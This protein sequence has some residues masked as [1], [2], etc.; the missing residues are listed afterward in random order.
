MPRLRSLSTLPLLLAATALAQTPAEPVVKLDPFV[1]TAHP[2]GADERAAS[3]WVIAPDS[4]ALPASRLAD[5]LLGVPGLTI[6]QPG[7]PGGRSTLY[8]RGGEENHTV[9]FLDGIP[10][11]DPTNNR[12]GGVDL[13]LLEPALLRSAAVV[14]GA[15]SVRYGP[16]AL[17]GV[18][19]LG[20]QAAP[21]NEANLL[22]EAGGDGFRRGAL[23]A[24]RVLADGSSSFQLGLAG[25]D[26]GSLADGSR[27]MR[28]FARGAFSTTFGSTNLRVSLWH[29]RH[30]ADSFPDESGGREFAVLRDLERREDRQTASAIHLDGQAG[31]GHWTA[32]AD[33]A[34]FD[35]TVTSPGVAAPPDNPYA[36]L[37]ASTDDTRL[38]R[39]RASLGYE[40]NFSGW[41][42]ALGLDAQRE[43]GRDA[44]SL[45]FGPM[46]L[47]TSF[48][49]DRERVGAYAETSG[50]LA[51]AVTLVAGARADHYGDGVT[52]GTFRGGLLGQIDPATQWRLNAG[53]AFK[54]A[55]FYALSNPL[56]GDATLKPEH[57][58]MIDTGLRHAFAGGRLLLDLTVFESRIR[59]GVDYDPVLGRLVN[60][61]GIRSRGTELAATWRPLATL[62]LAGSL[63][64]D[65]ARSNPGDE[66]MRNR[67]RWRSGVSASWTPVTTFSCTAALTATGNVTD[68]AKPTGD[69][70][71]GGWTRLDLA[72]RWSVTREFALT[73]ALDNALDRTYA[74]AIGFT[75]PGR[76]LRLGLQAQ[77]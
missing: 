16:D 40:Q 39:Y 42:T 49:A 30:N 47:P 45:Q 48:A 73:A 46:V 69:L 76:R 19:H 2:S 56:V 68:T 12:G 21:A 22:A 53:T 15:A 11:N 25:T 8:L 66:R 26:D 31:D 44:G 10:L 72:A 63:T 5:L 34:Q 1:V 54:P 58:R 74:E 59:N 62:A 7:G 55:S 14:R 9:V 33:A 57:A 77:F 43:Q 50:H 35:A 75:A 13:S 27:A 52:R 41:G 4:A 18:V 20:T 37:P 29:A 67:P 38:R 28:R 65:D 23:S 61:T 17:A 24:S 32:T 60:R 70:T 6:D 51:P 3:V 71:L 36:G 64:T